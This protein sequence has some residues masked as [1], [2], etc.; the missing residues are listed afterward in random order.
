MYWCAT[1][2]KD[3]D[4][5]AVMVIVVIIVVIVVIIVIYHYDLQWLK[6]CTYSTCNITLF[7]RALQ[8]L[9]LTLLHKL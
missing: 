3:C 5:C 7:N 1:R 9:S 2:E 4:L 6:S 8:S